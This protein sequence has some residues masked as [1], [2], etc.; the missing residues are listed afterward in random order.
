MR[1][2][3]KPA[4]VAN[5]RGRASEEHAVKAAHTQHVAQRIEQQAERFAAACGTAVDGDIRGRREEH[6]LRPGLRREA[7]LSRAA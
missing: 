1:L 6:R 7:L 5:L 3:P 2:V 4:G